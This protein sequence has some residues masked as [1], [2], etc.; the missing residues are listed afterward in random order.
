MPE[1]TFPCG[2]LVEW[3]SEFGFWILSEICSHHAEGIE[4]A[5]L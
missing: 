2:C 1:I 3:H 4:E 5:E